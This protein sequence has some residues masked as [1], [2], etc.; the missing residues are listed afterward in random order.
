MEGVKL[1]PWSRCRSQSLII[2]WSQWLSVRVRVRVLVRVLVLATYWLPKSILSVAQLQRPIW[3]FGCAFKVGVRIGLGEGWGQRVSWPGHHAF[4][5]HNQDG[6]RRRILCSTTVKMQVDFLLFCVWFCSHLVQ[7]YLLIDI[8]YVCMYLFVD[9]TPHPVLFGGW[10]F[11]SVKIHQT[12]VF[13]F[14]L[15]CSRLRRWEGSFQ[16]TS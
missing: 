2:A 1:Q 9:L 7:F 10:F 12:T 15:F 14:E 11:F 3:G 13:E 5:R 16:L 8:D 4:R 6:S